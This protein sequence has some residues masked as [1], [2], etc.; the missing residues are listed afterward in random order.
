MERE[1]FNHLFQMNVTEL[2]AERKTVTER[3]RSK[4]SAS[5]SQYLTDIDTYTEALVRL[6]AQWAAEARDKQRKE[7]R[8]HLRL[9][10]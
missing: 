5:D 4:W 3:I 10:K 6:R 2:E 9:V 1:T 7:A 8:S